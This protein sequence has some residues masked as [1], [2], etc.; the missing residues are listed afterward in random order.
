MRGFR[1]AP[2]QEAARLLRLSSAAPL[3]PRTGGPLAL[4]LLLALALA[5]AL[6]LLLRLPGGGSQPAPVLLRAAGCDATCL[7]SSTA[8]S[9]ART[10]LPAG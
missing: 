3:Q 1:G 4:P 10:L 7:L 6:A 8:A 2:L 5:L 9:S